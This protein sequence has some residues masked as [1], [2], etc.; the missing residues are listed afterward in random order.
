M[1]PKPIISLNGESMEEEL[2]DDLQLLLSSSE[3]LF[4]SKNPAVRLS[5]FLY[6]PWFT[7]IQVVLAAV[8]V[9]YYTGSPSFT[10][11]IVD[12]LIRILQVSREAERVVLA[13]LLVITRAHPV[14]ARLNIGSCDVLYL[15]DSN[16]SRRNIHGF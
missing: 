1:L 9:F 7:C 14:C 12:P 16:Y 11:R 4:R 2:D 5:P 15:P 10:S 8:R 3:P 13:Y 6:Y